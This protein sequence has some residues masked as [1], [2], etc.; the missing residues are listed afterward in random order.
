MDNLD[1]A[2][3]LCTLL[4]WAATGTIAAIMAFDKLQSKTLRILVSVLGGPLV[5]L[6]ASVTLIISV[7]EDLDNEL[8]QKGL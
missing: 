5:W 2:A 3:A 1:A 7:L 8:K 6:W 4:A